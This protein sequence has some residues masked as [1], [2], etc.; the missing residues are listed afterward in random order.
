M[1]PPVLLPP[2]P[3]PWLPPPLAAA[4]VA[5]APLLA[6][7]LAAA[8]VLLLGISP[9]GLRAAFRIPPLDLTRSQPMPRPCATLALPR[10]SIWAHALHLFM[11]RSSVNPLANNFLMADWF[12]LDT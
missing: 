7:E 9:F 4:L 10:C 2:P 5:E 11:V 3:P 8:P 6:L 12:Y 1:V